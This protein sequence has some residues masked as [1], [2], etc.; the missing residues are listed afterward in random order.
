MDT[1]KQFNLLPPCDMQD[2]DDNYVNGILKCTRYANRWVLSG[3][4]IVY[5][6]VWGQ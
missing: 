6:R 5:L 3:I 4:D 1:E 2:N